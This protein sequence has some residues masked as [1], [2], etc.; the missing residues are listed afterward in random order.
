MK[1]MSMPMLYLC[2]F[3]M[4]DR[5]TRDLVLALVLLIHAQKASQCGKPNFSVSPMPN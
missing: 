3:S 1:N 5:K 4:F 2:S